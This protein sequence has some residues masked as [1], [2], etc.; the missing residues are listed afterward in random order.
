MVNRFYIKL[1]KDSGLNQWDSKINIV[2]DKVENELVI[3]LA[4]V[5]NMGNQSFVYLLTKENRRLKNYL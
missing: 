2:Y 4:F 3:P 1:N 5:E